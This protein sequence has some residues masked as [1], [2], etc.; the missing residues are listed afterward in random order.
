MKLSELAN[1]QQISNIRNGDGNFDT[2]NEVY[3]AVGFPLCHNNHNTITW[4]EQTRIFLEFLDFYNE[5]VPEEFKIKLMERSQNSFD[6]TWEDNSITNNIGFHYMCEP[7][8][9]FF[10]ILLNYVNTGISKDTPSYDEDIEEWLDLMNIIKME[11]YEKCGVY[12]ETET[13]DDKEFAKSFLVNNFI[14]FTTEW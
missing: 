9:I 2:L 6:I 14:H 5:R 7:K 11:Y 3:T 13:D 12:L 4:E 10:G 8:I 1:D